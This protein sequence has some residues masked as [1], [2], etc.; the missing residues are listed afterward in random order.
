MNSGTEISKNQNTFVMWE[1]RTHWSTTI[2]AYIF[3]DHFSLSHLYQ[4]F[5]LRQSGTANLNITTTWWW[6]KVRL[7]GAPGGR[8]TSTPT[9]ICLHKF[10]QP[11][12]FLNGRCLSFC[13]IL[14]NALRTKLTLWDGYFHHCHHSQ[15]HKLQM[16]QSFYSGN[17]GHALETDKSVHEV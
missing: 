15:E 17:R 3:E 10:S 5:P 2:L 4:N 1:P 12:K 14:R 7:T 9:V 6:C 13:Y 8:G 11:L 16:I